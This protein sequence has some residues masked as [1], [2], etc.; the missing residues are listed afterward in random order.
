MG[1]RMDKNGVKALYSIF[2][3]L[4]VERIDLTGGHNCTRQEGG[5]K[6]SGGKSGNYRRY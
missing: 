5:G 1:R 2:T 6:G 4:K 3:L